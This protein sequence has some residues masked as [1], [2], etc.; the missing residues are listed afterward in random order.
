MAS[1]ADGDLE[2]VNM[3]SHAKAIM[4][5]WRE[6]SRVWEHFQDIWGPSASNH[7]TECK[8]FNTESLSIIHLQINK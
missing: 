4:S 1:F 5:V 6:P 7:L 2:F 8:Q 3:F